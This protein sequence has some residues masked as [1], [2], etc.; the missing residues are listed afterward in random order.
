VSLGR[1]ALGLLLAVAALAPTIRAARLLCARCCPELR[2][3]PAVL[4]E[5]IV[6]VATVVVV[7]ELLGTVGLFRVAP[8]V[9][10]MVL[11]GFGMAAVVRR[12]EARVELPDASTTPVDPR[13]DAAPTS[14]GTA[15]GVVVAVAALVGTWCTRVFDA[16][17]HG[18][19]TA[20]TLWYHMPIALRF[21]QSGW[22]SQLHFVDN[23]SLTTFFP[24]SSEL[25]HATGVLLFGTDWLSPLLNL[26]WLALALLAAWC[27]GA[28]AGVAPLTLVGTAIVLGLPEMVLD[29]PGSALTDVVS[30]ALVLA[31]VALLV[32]VG[33]ARPVQRWGTFAIA[34]LAT[35]LAVGTKFTMLAPAA[36]LTVYVVFGLGGSLRRRLAWWLGP[37][38]VAGGYFYVRN[39]L[40]TGSPLPNV[41]LGI[42][43]I[44]LPSAPSPGQD[45]LVKYLTDR[46]AWDA[47]FLPGF[48][49]ALGP[50]WWLILAFTIGGLVAVIVVRATRRS[51]WWVGFVG[52]V[53]LVAYVVSPQILTVRG[54]PFWFV[55][56]LRY[57]TPAIALGLMCVPILVAG[58]TRLVRYLFGGYVV[59]IVVTLAARTVWIANVKTLIAIPTHGTLPK[60]LG[61]VTGIGC[62]VAGTLVVLARRNAVRAS[63]LALGAVA[64]LVA[65]AG[66][67][68]GRYYV[69]H[70]YTGL[71][72]F[73]WARELRDER[74]ADL[75]LLV[76]YQ[77]YGADLSNHVQ[78]VAHRDAHGRSTSIRTCAAWRTALRD[79]RYTYAVVASP[80]FAFPQAKVPP[81]VA[82]TKSDPGARLVY[83][84]R[85]PR[86]M[87]EWVFELRSPPD[88]ASCPGAG[89][90]SER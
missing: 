52:L 50:L 63:P 60:V 33:A 83:T 45:A 26:G 27:I 74:I 29:D 10:A 5:T 76:Q 36:A 80:D 8:F 32:Y 37:L 67:G 3:A 25:L 39:V 42:G 57:L 87:G 24:A 48:R 54:R 44:H 59:T 73:A 66:F 47:N 64:V 55:V 20:D 51:Y 89:A 49:V 58:R 7:G 69:D 35:G 68:V 9:G 65:V 88:P 46:K 31:A 18:M 23:T 19:L 21:V 4:A 16:L 28:P 82:W 53:T 41:A 70:R 15:I 77:L 30:L 40:R 62:A 17:G 22:T 13:L 85:R 12:F 90:R 78:Y 86:E 61:V 11:A 6:V 84:S 38:F 81:A 1:Y 14:I 34:A 43:P 72:G 2:G 56:N 79:G 71:K 75:N